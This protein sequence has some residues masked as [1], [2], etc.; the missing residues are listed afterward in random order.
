MSPPGRMRIVVAMSGGVDERRASG[1]VLERVAVL[2]AGG[3]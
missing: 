3:R 2:L 1:A